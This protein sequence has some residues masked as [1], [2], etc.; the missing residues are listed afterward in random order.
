MHSH[1]KKRKKKSK[2]KQN[3][4]THS[5]KIFERLESE[6]NDAGGERFDFAW[7]TKQQQC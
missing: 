7:R 6:S 4:K 1:Q 2:T 5:D 3:K